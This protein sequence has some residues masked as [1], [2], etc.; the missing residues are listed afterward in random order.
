MFTEN[1]ETRD[2]FHELI[3]QGSIKTIIKLIKH[4][5]RNNGER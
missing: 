4:A 1:V 2:G 3:H 5:C